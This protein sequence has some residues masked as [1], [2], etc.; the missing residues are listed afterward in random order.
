[1]PPNAGLSVLQLVASQASPNSKLPPLEATLGPDQSQRLRAS[2]ASIN[3]GTR[4]SLPEPTAPHQALSPLD[5]SQRLSGA[6]PALRSTIKRK[7]D[8][9][10]GSMSGE[11]LQGELSVGAMSASGRGTHHRGS[12]PWRGRSPQR[13]TRDKDDYSY[14]KLI[15]TLRQFPNTDDFV[16]LRRADRDPSIYNPYALDVVAFAEVDPEDFYTMSARGLI[17]VQGGNNADYASL[18]QWERELQLYT[19]LKKLKVFALFRMWKSFAL[20][21]RA[22]RQRKAADA[23]GSLS[24]HLFLLS[25][26]FQG[27]LRRFHQLCNEL[28]YMRLHNFKPDRTYSLEDLADSQARGSSSPACNLL[29]LGHLFKASGEMLALWGTI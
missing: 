27:P 9:L 7:A 1:M 26:V 11:L 25:P 20:W 21:R 18:D 15:Q 2:I 23:K 12:P 8:T 22:L 16:Y 24:R 13:T 3:G 17:H 10:Q 29:S 14:V 5:A 28:S 6:S 4:S 19:A